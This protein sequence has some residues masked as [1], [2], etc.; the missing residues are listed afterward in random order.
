[1]NCTICGK[2][3]VLIPSAKE[4]SDKHGQTP[5]FYT[6]LFTAHGDCIVA[7]RSAEFVALMRQLTNR[8]KE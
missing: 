5:A 6:A 7:K 8:T 2:V 3:I 1:M 4:R